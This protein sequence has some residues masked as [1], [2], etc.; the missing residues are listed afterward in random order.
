MWWLH[1]GQ[2]NG[3]TRTDVITNTRTGG[4]AIRKFQWD[5]ETPLK[6]ASFKLED[7]A[8]NVIGTYT[9]GSDGIVTMLYEFERNQLYTL[10]E[11]ASPNGYIGLQKALS[12]KLNNDDSITLYQSDG[13]TPWNRSTDLNW[14]NSKPGAR[15]FT[16]FIDVY[17]KPFNFKI[18]KMDSEDTDIQLDSAH[19]ALYKQTN[20]TIGGLQKNKDPLTGFEDMITV[21]GTV[22][23]CGGDSGR[24]LNPGSNGS[25]F[26]LT[27]THAPFNYIQLEDDILF[28]V[29]PLGIPS[30]VSDSYHG[31]LVETADSYTYTLSVP[32]EKD[33]PD[34]ETLTV[35]KRVDGNAGSRDKDFTFTVTISG[36]GE[37]DGFV[38]AKNGEAQPELMPRTGGTFTLKHN[39]NVDIVLPAGVTVTVTEDYG[40][41]TPSFKLD[42]GESEDI[43]SK[44][45]TEHSQL[46]V[47]NTL[48]MIVPTGVFLGI[49]IPLA[50]L[51]SAFAVIV[52][53]LY[54]KKRGVTISHKRK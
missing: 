17:N 22:Y 29:S 21:D 10:T 5:S 1:Q 42:D 48:N 35:K 16:A 47:T 46:I 6:G 8:G 13:T 32:N 12:F 49:I 15:G 26:F 3:S 19:F 31:N 9:S 43:T 41:Y 40:D 38:W 34:L 24:V 52:F 30:I 45:F 54:R 14:A 37:G 44:T 25:V 20:T 7:N 18:E 27:E 33:D 53:I 4:I 2:D 51:L 11:T 39:D 50:F 23:I 28:Y 36:A